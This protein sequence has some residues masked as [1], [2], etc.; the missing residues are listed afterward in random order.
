MKSVL[1]L[2]GSRY[3]GSGT[4]VRTSLA[5][6]ALRNQPVHVTKIREKRPTPGLRPQH[7]TSVRAMEALCR[8]RLVGA[9]VGSRELTF[10]PGGTIESGRYEW[11]IGTAGST[12]LLGMAVL[13]LLIFAPARSQVRIQGGLFQDYAPNPYPMKFLFSPFLRQMGAGL[14]LSIK[15]P[16]YYPKGGGEIEIETEPLGEPLKPLRLLEKGKLKSIKGVALSSHLKQV[17][18]SERIRTSALKFLS[19]RG[20]SA[21]IECVYEEK[22]D[23]PGAAFCLWAETDTGCRF[24]ADL[25]GKPGLASEAIGQEVARKLCSYLEGKGTVDPF[26]ADQLIPY[27][28]LAEGTSEYLLPEVTEHVESNLWLIKTLLGVSYQLEGLHLKIKGMGFRP[29]IIS[30]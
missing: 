4:I 10:F 3:S 13:P 17:R 9:E 15:K 23:Q 6:A 19:V 28:G 7:L 26:L 16:G 14:K 1:E 11:A 12:T 25:A 18:V 24:G 29:P 22:A 30:S 5:L 2:D 20:Y 8:G 21:E 27:A